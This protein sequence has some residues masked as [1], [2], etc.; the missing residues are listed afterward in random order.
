M[1]YGKFPCLPSCENRTETPRREA[2]MQSEEK[3]WEEAADLLCPQLS[4]SGS[5][6]QPSHPRTLL[7]SHPPHPGC[8]FLI[9]HPLALSPTGKMSSIPGNLLTCY[10]LHASASGTRKIAIEI[11]VSVWFKEHLNSQASSLHHQNNARA[12]LFHRGTITNL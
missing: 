9:S 4:L 7:P 8:D 11:H 1:D 12:R 10:Y 5:L 3:S 6:S 2:G